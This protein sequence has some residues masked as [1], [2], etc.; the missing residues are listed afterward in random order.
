MDTSILTRIQRIN[1]AVGRSGQNSAMPKVIVESRNP[2]LR[3]KQRQQLGK[4]K[5]LTVQPATRLRYNKA[6]DQFLLFLK[7]SRLQLPR[8]RDRVDALAAEYLEHLWFSGKGRGLASDTLASLQDQDPRLKGQLQLSWR[9]L[10]TWH[11]HE[12]PSRA[13]PFPEQVLHCLVGW[14]L[15]QKQFGFAV[16]LLV[17]FYGM[18][19]TGELLSLRHRDFSFSV[20]SGVAVVNLGYTK[21]G[22]RMGV[23]ESVTLTHELTLRFLRQ[24][25][26]LSSP[27]HSFCSSAATWRSLF[28]QGIV[29][30]K[31]KSFEF[32]PYSLRRGGATWYF[33]KYGSLDRVM[34]I[35]RWQAARTARLYLN[36]ALATLA[37]MR[38]EPHRA[39]FSPFLSTFKNTNPSRY[40]TLE[41]PKGRAGGRG[42]KPKN[43]KKMG[44]SS[45][46]NRHKK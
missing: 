10:K 1:Q 39:W 25:L 14:G 7:E 31:L 16:S 46:K 23:I 30:L 33:T 28:H 37:D 27:A 5:E 43:T 2:Q 12:I 35:G 36:E 24:W 18:L 13:P 9:L 42:R 22:Q 34:V 11:T 20:Q 19:R 45:K 41:P 44:K 29:A 21:G 26:K 6:L 3:A 38:L 4:L 40:Q 8:Q 17:G 15:M 32:R